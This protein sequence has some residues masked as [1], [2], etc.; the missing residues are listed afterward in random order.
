MHIFNRLYW[1]DMLPPPP[2]HQPTSS[3]K[4]T[5]QIEKLI[6]MRE[7]RRHGTL[8]CGDAPLLP[9][10]LQRA[11]YLSPKNSFSFLSS[12][13]AGCESKSFKYCGT[14]H[15][16][17]VGLVRHVAHHSARTNLLKQRRSLLGHRFIVAP[18]AVDYDSKTGARIDDG[19][20]RNKKQSKAKQNKLTE[21]RRQALRATHHMRASVEKRPADSGWSAHLPYACTPRNAPKVPKTSHFT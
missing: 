5:R 4:V 14:K 7:H 17:G 13:S 6:N 18:A 15:K 19:D 1:R 9:L 16:A 10:P 2:P 3:S 12:R 8:E 21:T 11:I 20:G